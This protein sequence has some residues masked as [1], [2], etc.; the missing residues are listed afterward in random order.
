MK[1]DEKV[2]M[3]EGLDEAQLAEYIVEHADLESVCVWACEYL[4][5][6]YEENKK[7]FDADKANHIEMLT[8]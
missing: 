6:L 8:G 7:A 4:H 3:L 2:Q 1:V 5:N